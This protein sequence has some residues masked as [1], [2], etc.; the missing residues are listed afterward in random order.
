[1]TD[2][3]SFTS[4]SARFRL[5]F[6]FSGQAQKE[7][8]V[9]EAHAIADA[10]FHPAVEGEDN[11]PPGSPQ[12]GECW[13]VGSAPTGA[14]LGKAG[15][16]ACYQL[17]N[18]IFVTPRDGLRIL[19]KQTGQDIRWSGGAWQRPVAPAAPTGG[20]TADNEAR[21]AVAALINAL[22]SAGILTSN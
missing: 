7:L 16:L 18:W 1:M 22:I 9:N 13:L 19:D 3:I 15:A 12:D 17:N 6:L 4:A 20:T 14:W 11:D 10:L 21:S 5:P 8:F 2:P